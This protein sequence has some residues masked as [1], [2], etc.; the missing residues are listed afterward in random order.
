M[1]SYEFLKKTISSIFVV[2]S[3]ERM[4]VWVRLQILYFVV[5]KRMLI[6]MQL[7]IF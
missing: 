5:K 2:R 6:L 1:K 7:E 4:A 3:Q